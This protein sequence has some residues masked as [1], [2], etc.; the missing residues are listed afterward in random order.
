M[1][2]RRRTLIS[3]PVLIGFAELFDRSYGDPRTP[4][5]YPRVTPARIGNSLLPFP[6]PHCGAVQPA[7]IDPQTRKGYWDRERKHSWCPSCLGRYDINQKGAPLS[8]P[9]E[10]GATSAPAIV[11]RGGK[12]EILA[13]SVDSLG[14][15][16]AG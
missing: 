12:T 5:P 11:E 14:M 10:I 8:K 13:E 3:G 7:V 15:L 4:R 1:P 6:C 9:I 2:C 16:G